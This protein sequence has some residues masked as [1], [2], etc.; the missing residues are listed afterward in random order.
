MPNFFA[1]PQVLGLI[2][3]DLLINLLSIRTKQNEKTS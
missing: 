2:R 1:A 3:N